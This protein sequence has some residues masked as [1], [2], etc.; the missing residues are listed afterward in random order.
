MK[1]RYLSLILAIPLLLA[2]CSGG[3]DNTDAASESPATSADSA[4]AESSAAELADLT[5][6]VAGQVGYRHGMDCTDPET[7]SLHFTV[8]SFDVLNQCD[9]SSPS[10]FDQRPADTRLVKAT[11]LIETADL[12]T[13]YRAGEF[14]VW[15]EWSALVEDGANV[16]LERSDWCY[17]DGTQPW[18]GSIW[19]GD[20]ER[21]I[22]Y[23][24]V[25]N[26]ATKLRLTETLTGAR[27]E[28]DVPEAAADA[29]PVA[30]APAEEAA[31]EQVEAP[32]PPVEATPNPPAPV[33]APAPVPAPAPAPSPAPVVGIT[34][35]PS[36]ETPRVL[37][38]QIASCGDPSMHQT[39]TTFFTDGTSGWTETCSSQMQ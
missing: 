8:E 18:S 7:C 20:T 3:A 31:P 34:G 9:G 37:D 39:G 4:A 27:W 26:A 11:V 19:P 13:D 38:K 2:G 24:D 12:G 5:E 15:T 35:A 21:R 25:P 29:A 14:P 1:R 17:N 32:A 23:M 10:G 28:F 30:E 22:H 16:P 36:V 6:G 33:E